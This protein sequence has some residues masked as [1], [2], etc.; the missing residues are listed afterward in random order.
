MF[1]IKKRIISQEGKDNF[2]AGPY[3]ENPGPY[4][5]LRAGPSPY[6]SLLILWGINVYE[7]LKGCVAESPLPVYL[8]QDQGAL[9]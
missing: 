2:L 3:T 1:M 9:N 5:K 6:L 8:G 7:N 4:T